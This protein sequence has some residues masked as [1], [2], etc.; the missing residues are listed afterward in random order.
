LFALLAGLIRSEMGL[1][2]QIEGTVTVG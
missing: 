1:L 2:G